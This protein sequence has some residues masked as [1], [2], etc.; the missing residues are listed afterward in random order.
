MPVDEIENTCDSYQQPI[1]AMIVSEEGYLQE[2]IWE[3]HHANEKDVHG[4]GNEYDTNVE[5]KERFVFI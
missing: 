2:S 3:T 1:L 4:D 5:F